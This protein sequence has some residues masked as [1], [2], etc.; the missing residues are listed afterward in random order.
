MT[1]QYKSRRAFFLASVKLIITQI[2][3]GSTIIILSTEENNYADKI[4]KALKNEGVEAA[5]E[6]MTKKVPTNNRK[7]IYD[8]WG[9]PRGVEI[10]PQKE[11]FSGWKIKPITIQVL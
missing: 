5:A 8:N 6:R 4:I 10:L 1:C 9:E 3:D 7:M 2:R 11:V